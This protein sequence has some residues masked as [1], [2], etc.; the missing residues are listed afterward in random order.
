ML[1]FLRALDLVLVGVSAIVF[2][3]GRMPAFGRMRGRSQSVAGVRLIAAAE[4]IWLLV[5]AFGT[6]HLWIM[7]VGYTAAPA[8]YFLGHHLMV[9]AG[10]VVPQSGWLRTP[11]VRIRG[12]GGTGGSGRPPSSRTGTRRATSIG[13]GPKASRATTH[14]EPIVRSC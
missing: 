1:T 2:V 13:I 9:K 7:C 12:A 11:C 6:Q 10:W 8:L 5:L 4:I 14:R 3:G